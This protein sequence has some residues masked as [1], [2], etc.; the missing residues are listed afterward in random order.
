MLSGISLNSL[1]ERYKDSNDLSL[2]ISA[3]SQH[4]GLG[5]PFQDNRFA[6]RGGPL[7][8]PIARASAGK[9]AASKL[10]GVQGGHASH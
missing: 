7:L 5:L 8:C 9:L 2:L 10:R 3:A 1:L 6:F 4:R